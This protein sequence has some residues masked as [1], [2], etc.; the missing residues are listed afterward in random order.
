MLSAVSY[1]SN[2]SSM[3]ADQDLFASCEVDSNFV[4]FIAADD[5]C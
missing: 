2:R 1:V 4:S 5:Q 3:L